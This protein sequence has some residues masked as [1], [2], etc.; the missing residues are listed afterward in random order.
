MPVQRKHVRQQV[1][2]AIV[3]E[4]LGIEDVGDNVFPFQVFP[5][6]DEEL[7]C[8]SVLTP[9]EILDPDTETTSTTQTRVLSVTLEIRCKISDT[10]ADV[11]DRIHM[12]AEEALVDAFENGVK[13]D[14]GSLANLLVDM[15]DQAFDIEVSAE[16]EKP[17]ALGTILFFCQ[18]RY[19]ALDLSTTI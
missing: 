7:P 6:T 17:V 11:I 4:L 14:T 13:T 1:R 8:I 18:Y 2:E 5:K 3:C 15:T 9:S 19:D 12:N 10:F 16:L